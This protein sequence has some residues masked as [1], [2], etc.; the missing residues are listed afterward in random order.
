MIDVFEAADICSLWWSVM[1]W[2]DPGVCLYALGST[3]RV[4]SEEHRQQC[5][6]Y[7]TNKCIPIAQERDDEET[8]ADIVQL[9]DLLDYIRN[10]DIEPMEVT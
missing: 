5:I 3:G 10:A 9:E 2:S 6:D 7:I 4:Q 8:D 1:T